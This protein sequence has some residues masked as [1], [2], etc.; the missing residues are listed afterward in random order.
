MITIKE[1]KE[2]ERLAFINGD[3]E[4]AETLAE[5]IEAREE[6]QRRFV[7]EVSHGYL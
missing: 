7:E 1:L 5:L 3:Y 4:K 2:Q 6:L